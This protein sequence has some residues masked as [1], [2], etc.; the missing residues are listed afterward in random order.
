MRNQLCHYE[1]P[2]FAPRICTLAL[3]VAFMDS[4]LAGVLVLLFDLT[5][6][7]FALLST[8]PALFIPFPIVDLRAWIFPLIVALVVDCTHS[9]SLCPLLTG[10]GS[11]AHSLAD[12]VSASFS[13]EFSSVPTCCQTALLVSDPE[14]LTM[15][16]PSVTRSTARLC[17]VSILAL[18]CLDTC[19]GI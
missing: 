16:C 12:V 1:T 6:A 17:T 7:A 5:F 15:R 18:Q 4:D 2:A 3:A 19:V 11:L 9:L 14:H 10:L 8:Y 13:V